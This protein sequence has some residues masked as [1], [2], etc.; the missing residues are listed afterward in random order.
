MSMSTYLETRNPN[1]T[2]CFVDKLLII[3]FHLVSYLKKNKKLLRIDIYTGHPTN[4]LAFSFLVF[5]LVKL[6]N[7]SVRAIR[8]RDRHYVRDSLHSTAI[9]KIHQF[10]SC[11]IT[12][13]G[14]SNIQ[15]VD[16]HG[17]MNKTL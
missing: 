12:M 9:G 3:G 4:F 5:L 8:L 17:K 6:E 16:V 11:I 10:S 15:N 13:F 7:T 14:L 2:W 1:L